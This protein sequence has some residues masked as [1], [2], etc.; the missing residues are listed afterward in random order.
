MGLSHPAAAST[1]LSE[2]LCCLYAL[3]YELLFSILSFPGTLYKA[4]L[5]KSSCYF[6]NGTDSSLSS[7]CCLYYNFSDHKNHLMWERI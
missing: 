5:D 7:K 2:P 3:C 6:P 4:F 1:H